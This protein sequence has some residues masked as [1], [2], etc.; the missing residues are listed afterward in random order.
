VTAAY[1]RTVATGKEQ[2]ISVDGKRWT[3]AQWRG[4]TITYVTEP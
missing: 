2:R 4:D 1:V 3:L